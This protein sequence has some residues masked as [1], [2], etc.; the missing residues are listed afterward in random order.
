M[1]MKA[2]LLIQFITINDEISLQYTFNTILHMYREIVKK[3]KHLL[4]KGK[5][6]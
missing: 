6:L 3:M 2:L 4:K 5:C 1:S